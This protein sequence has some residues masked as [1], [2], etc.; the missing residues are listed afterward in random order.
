MPAAIHDVTYDELPRSYA[1]LWFFAALLGAGFVVDLVL[2]NAI[3]HLLGWLLAAVLVLG[4]NALVVHAVRTTKTLH[5][6][7]DELRVGDDAIARAEIA[8]ISAAPADTATAPVLGWPSGRPRGMKSVTLRLADGRNVVVPTRFPDRLQ[9]ALDIQPVPE[10]R[11]EIRAAEASDLELLEEIDDRAEALFR[12]AQYELP[13][14]PFDEAAVRHAKVIF[15]AGRPPVGYI[16]LDEVDGMAYVAELA[17]LPKWMRRGIGTG[18]IER[19]CEWAR[20]NG[21]RVITLTTYADV[22]WNAPYYAARGFLE[23]THAPPG[24]AAIREHEK[25]LG[26]DDVGRRIVMRRELE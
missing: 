26:L 3:A 17:V 20:G 7:R 16:H 14:I 9:A 24:L 13:D 6:T 1:I 10:G 21:Y 25:T 2:G 15:V 5:L 8:G 18:L 23:M 12:A 19:A 4:A 11:L 22:P